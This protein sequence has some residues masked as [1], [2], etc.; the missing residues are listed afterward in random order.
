[1]LSQKNSNCKCVAPKCTS[2]AGHSNFRY[3]LSKQKKDGVPRDPGSDQ[4]IKTL[5]I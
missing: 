1:M 2:I 5:S 4:N 3:V